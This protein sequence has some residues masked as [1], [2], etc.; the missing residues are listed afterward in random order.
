MATARISEAHKNVKAG[1]VQPALPDGSAKG[2]VSEAPAQTKIDKGQLLRWSRALIAAPDSFTINRKLAAQFQKR[3]QA[4]K[5]HG[6]VDWAVAE[7]L[8]G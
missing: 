8:A 1:T 5:E 6:E 3:D 7:G 2:N 4:I